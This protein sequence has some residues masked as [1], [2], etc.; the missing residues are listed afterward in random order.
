VVVSKNTK[1]G[2]E[3]IN[4][5]RKELGLSQLKI[6][7]FPGIKSENGELISSHRIRNGEINRLGKPYINEQ[8]YKTNL[9]LP[10]DL[11]KEL[12]KPFGLLNDDVLKDK[13]QSELI[14]SVGDVTTEKLNKLGFSHQLSVVDFKVARE[15]IFSSFSDLGFSGNEKIVLAKNHSGRISHDSL[16]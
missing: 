15:N 4:S 12:E 8:W 16:I 6:L 1:L 10:D 14:I 5:K 9:S 7:I 3:I 11:R 2:A 13:N